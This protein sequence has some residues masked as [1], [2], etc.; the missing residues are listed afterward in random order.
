MKDLKFRYCTALRDKHK[1]TSN[2]YIVHSKKN[3]QVEIPSALSMSTGRF[4]N[5]STLFLALFFF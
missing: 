5:T 4:L 1:E 3:L 2:P